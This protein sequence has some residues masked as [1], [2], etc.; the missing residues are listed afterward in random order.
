MRLWVR[1]KSWTPILVLPND[2]DMLRLLGGLALVVDVTRAAMLV[3]TN[4]YLRPGRQN[5]VI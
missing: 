4:T 1:L 3:A 2:C 5:D